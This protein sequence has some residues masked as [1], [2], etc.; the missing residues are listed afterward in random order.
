MAQSQEDK[1]AQ[2]AAAAEK[3]AQKDA[4]RIAKEDADKADSAKLERAE[5]AEVALQ[6]QEDREAAG[7][8]APIATAPV[9]EIEI[10][11]LSMH[12]VV[13]KKG[14]V[15]IYENVQLPKSYANEKGVKKF[16][17]NN[18]QVIY[19]TQVLVKKFS[20]NVVTDGASEEAIEE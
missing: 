13:A 12:D 9:D 6:A 11:V 18:G 7:E 16:E 5:K 4:E 14:D 1:A 3:T 20:N 10:N 17:G 15:Y 8:P 19:Y 2:L